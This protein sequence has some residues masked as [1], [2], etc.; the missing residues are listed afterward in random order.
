ME[1]VHQTHLSIIQYLLILGA[2]FF[3]LMII[4]VQHA[5]GQQVALVTAVAKGVIAF[6]F[7]FLSWVLVFSFLHRVIGNQVDT[8]GTQ[9]P[10]LSVSVKY[11]LYTWGVSTAGSKPP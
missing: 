4:R 3:T 2:M 1:L 11:F 7:F 10:N 6:F 8:S 9:Y 5:V